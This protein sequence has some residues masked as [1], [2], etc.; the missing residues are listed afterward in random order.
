MITQN[1]WEAAKAV[2][3]EKFIA[4]QSLRNKNISNKQPNLTP[5]AIRGSRTK[6]TPK[7]A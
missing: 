6:K 3:R 7:L 4:I 1:L 5:K 2:L